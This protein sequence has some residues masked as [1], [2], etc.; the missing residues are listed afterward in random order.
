MIRYTTFARNGR[1]IAGSASQ[2][3][4][5][6]IILSL[7]DGAIEILQS[8]LGSVNILV[9]QED[10]EPD[11]NA[12][13]SISPR[14]VICQKWEESE[15]GCGVRPNGY[16]LH[17]SEEARKRYIKAYWGRMSNLPPAT[18]SVVVAYERP[19]GFPYLCQ[20]H[21]ETYQKVIESDLDGLY[22]YSNDWPKVA[23]D[24]WLRDDGKS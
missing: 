6:D 21:E 22:F 5:A 8:R 24:G 7:K 12:T 3:A 14:T 23:A 1:I 19:S 11:S 13:D 9:V 10:G 4:E 2:E 16:S 18:P 15:I 20:P 17:R